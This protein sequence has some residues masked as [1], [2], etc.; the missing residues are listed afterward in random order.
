MTPA[1]AGITTPAP[2]RASTR[3][4]L[5]ALLATLALGLTQLPTAFNWDQSMFVLGGRRL[6]EGGV[7]YRDFW[8][9]KQPGIY[10]FYALAG[11]IFGFTEP[12]I[13]LFEL[14]WML[15]FAAVLGVTLRRRW[16]PGPAPALAP[17]LTV[18]V[19]YAVA[20]DLHLTQVEG[21]VGLP[22][23][24]TLWFATD[25][26]GEEPRAWRAFAS[27]LCG[28]AALLFKLAF[29]P[30]VG[31]FWLMALA[32]AW[33]RRGAGPAL[34]GVALPLAAGVALPLAATLAY[35]AHHGLL[36]TLRWTW[37]D[38][39][40][41]LL[42]RIRGTHVNRLFDG[43]Q[44]YLLRL[45]PW[46]GLAAVGA[47]ALRSR[48]DALGAGLGLW[49]AA[50]FLV[51][52]VQRWSW[53]QYHYVLLIPPAGVLAAAGAQAVGAWV[54]GRVRRLAVLGL[55]ALGSAAI[56]M[57]GM[58]T[59]LLA[60]ERFALTAADRLA[61]QKRT[62]P[63]VLG[64]SREADFLAAPGRQPGTIFILD[65]PVLYRLAPRPAAPAFRG[66]VFVQEMDEPEWSALTARL[67][68]APPAWL[69]VERHH[70]PLVSGGAPRVASFAAFLAASYRVAET[71]ERG[72][73]YERVR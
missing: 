61:Y 2:P 42:T 51:I 66:V 48:R 6:A 35:F 5:I 4:L 9:V 52:L 45:A 56:A 72:V 38:Y 29:L 26:P 49:F 41:F 33:R 34:A 43:V 1:E 7:L 20:G 37:F 54:P 27:G 64:F 53:W 10:W 70:V 57:A 62:S 68:A 3:G 30:L 69:M 12:G 36:G 47:G 39:P 13:H 16:G 32:F 11:R 23:Y 17:L 18:G 67:R 44:W 63:L 19:Y 71:T 46:L 60:R 31:A 50:G 28:G 22:L 73:W 8:D 14:L 55:V 58:R 21:L 25:G 59:V 40:A 24:L 15:A 65:D